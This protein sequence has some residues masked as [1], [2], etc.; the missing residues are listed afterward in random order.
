MAT[1]L[2]YVSLLSLLSPCCDEIMPSFTDPL[3]AQLGAGTLAHILIK[4]S[5]CIIISADY[6]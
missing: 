2:R 4:L 3:L 5:I 1:A 6:S